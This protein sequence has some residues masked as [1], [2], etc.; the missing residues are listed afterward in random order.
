MA[1]KG[2]KVKKIPMRRCIGCREHFP[3]RDLIR[4]VRSPEGSTALDFTGRAPGRG[5][6]LCARTA[7][8]EKARKT[9]RLEQN[10]SCSIS[11]DVYDALQ[12]E[13]EA[14]E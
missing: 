12:K 11:E 1:E 7:C 5:A 13:L 9:R 4:V 14:A 3:K 6:Y 2:Q 10:L 8:F